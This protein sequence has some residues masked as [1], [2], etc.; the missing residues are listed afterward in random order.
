MTRDDQIRATVAQGM[1]D[2]EKV[3]EAL[4]HAAW[5]ERRDAGRES[6]LSDVASAIERAN[7]PPNADSREVIAIRLLNA[8]E[9]Y[10]RSALTDAAESDTP[11]PDDEEND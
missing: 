6:I 5:L 7:Y 2:S 1:Q 4:T 10:A 3:Y 9:S 8:L 11:Q